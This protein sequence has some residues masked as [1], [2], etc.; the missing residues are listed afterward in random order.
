MR[1]LFVNPR[2]SSISMSLQKISMNI[3]CLRVPIVNGSPHVESACELV[4]H[5]PRL[6]IVSPLDEVLRDRFN[7]E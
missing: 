5:G 3:K 6:E 1:D 2:K 4:L 7:H